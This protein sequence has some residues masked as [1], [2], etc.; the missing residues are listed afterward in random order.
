MQKKIVA[1][2]TIAR[3]TARDVFTQTDANPNTR[4]RVEA[5]HSNFS[6]RTT[7][8]LNASVSDTATQ[9]AAPALAAPG[10][11]DV[12]QLGSS[13]TIDAG[14]D[15]ADNG[16]ADVDG[17]VRAIR[18]P[19]MAT[20]TGGV[21]PNALATSY[22]FEYG[23]TAAYGQTTAPQHAGSGTAEVRVTE[24]LSGLTPG[25][26]YRYRIVGTNTKG[27]TAGADLT[28]TTHA[29]P[30]PPAPIV[31]EL[32]LHPKTFAIGGKV[33]SVVA[34]GK[35]RKVPVGT[36][37]R[38]TLNQPAT[39]K[40]TFYRLEAGRRVG[41]GCRAQ[42]RANRAKPRCTRRVAMRRTLSVEG[43]AGFDQIRFQGRLTKRDRLG[44]GSHELA[45]VATD[46]LGRSSAPVRAGFRIVRR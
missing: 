8:G 22:H 1:V 34:A 7:D 36:T 35:K 2:N 6:T 26:T 43:R 14:V 4:T 30:P 11:G 18:S 46:S 33:P 38:F 5:D 9:T 10:A 23:P 15:S 40:L 21:N 39:A 16:S 28:F 44:F 29:A 12:R 32:A 25:T 24:H 20:V 41:G 17:D 42:S 27:T 37:I 19:D 45:M 13:P 3:G 31:S